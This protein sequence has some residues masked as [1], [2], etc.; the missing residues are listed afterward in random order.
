MDLHI[1]PVIV[2]G[3]CIRELGDTTIIITEK[4]NELHS[5]DEMGGFIW[6][7]IDG[8]RSAMNI[9]ELICREY[10]VERSLAESDLVGFLASLKDKN[11]VCF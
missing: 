11:L 8:S 3:L 10:D 2:D 1:I 6:N 9:L 7:S 4:G 5:L